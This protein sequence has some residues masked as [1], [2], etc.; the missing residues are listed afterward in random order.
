MIRTYCSKH[1]MDGTID[2]SDIGA[3]TFFAAAQSTSTGSTT[4]GNSTSALNQLLLTTTAAFRIVSAVSPIGDAFPDVLVKFNIGH[5]SATNA[6][7][8]INKELN[9]GYFT[10]P[11]PQGVTTRT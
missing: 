4:T 10:R 5:N 8:P 7:R 2:Q 3:N 11:T 1:K 6:V 9:N